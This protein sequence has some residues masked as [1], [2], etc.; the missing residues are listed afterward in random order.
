MQCSTILTIAVRNFLS[1]FTFLAFFLIL[2][3]TRMSVECGKCYILTTF[4]KYIFNFF[5]VNMAHIYIWELCPFTIKL[6]WFYSKSWR[7]FSAFNYL[8]L[9]FLNWWYERKISLTIAT[10]HR[11]ECHRHIHP[12]TYHSVNVKWKRMRRS[13]YTQ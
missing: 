9:P 4:G 2:Y 3:T 11:I 5:F 7:P 8:F 10:P 13:L 6:H 1:S 12:P